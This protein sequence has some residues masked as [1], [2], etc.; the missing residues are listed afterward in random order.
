MIDLL[1][2]IAA[3]LIALGLSPA[4]TPAYDNFNNL[5][6][7]APVCWE[8]EVIVLVIHDPYGDLDTNNVVGC[9]PAD[10]LPTNGFRP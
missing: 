10:N 1:N 4:P 8:D 6:A 9:V 5:I 2:W 3:I 7:S